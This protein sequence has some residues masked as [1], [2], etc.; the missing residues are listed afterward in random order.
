M[1]GVFCVLR[2]WMTATFLLP[3][4][5][6]FRFLGAHEMFMACLSSVS[7]F[8]SRLGYLWSCVSIEVNSDWGIVDHPACYNFVSMVGEQQKNI[9]QEFLT[10]ERVIHSIFDKCDEWHTLLGCGYCMLPFDLR[11]G[12]LHFEVLVATDS[13]WGV[14]FFMLVW[15][16]SVSRLSWPPIFRRK[17]QLGQLQGPM[18]RPRR[19]QLWH[20]WRLKENTYFLPA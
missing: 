3:G 7:F 1:L 8:C 5:L 14:D 2:C 12:V 9:Y 15:F 4:L 18:A 13:F 11:W 19:D 17:I 10:F 20:W 16:L 6:L